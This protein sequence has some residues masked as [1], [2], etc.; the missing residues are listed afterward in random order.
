[1]MLLIRTGYKTLLVWRCAPQD[2][3]HVEKDEMLL[4]ERGAQ[5]RSSVYRQMRCCWSGLDMRHCWSRDVL[6]RKGSI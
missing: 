2:K 4:V 5:R 3:E 6:H 1:M